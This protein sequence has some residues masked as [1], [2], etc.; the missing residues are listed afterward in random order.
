MNDNKSFP[1]GLV[2]VVDQ[3]YNGIKNHKAKGVTSK[4]MK[5]VG[6]NLARARNQKGGK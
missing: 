2:P 4:A 5:Q 1:K 3:N 6:R